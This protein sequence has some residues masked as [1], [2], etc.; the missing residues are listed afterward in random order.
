MKL[1]GSRRALLRAVSAPALLG[2]ASLP[3]QSPHASGSACTRVAFGTWTPPLDWNRAGHP[4]SA[5][6]IGARLRQARDS[7]FSGQAA[8]GGRD[9]MQWEDSGGVRRL[10]LSPAWW[11]AG[12]VITFAPVEGAAGDTLTGEAVALVGDGRQPPPRADARLLRA[13]CHTRSP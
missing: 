11:P 6:G 4:D 2:A 7:V 13:G 8:A 12:V 1:S 3:A 9:E 5:S 10:F